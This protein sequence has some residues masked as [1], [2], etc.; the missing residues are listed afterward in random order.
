VVSVTLP[1][2]RGYR[3][4][5]RARQGKARLDARFDAFVGRFRERYGFEPLWL[6]TDDVERPNG[7]GST[8]RLNVVLERSRQYRGFHA[9]EYAYD[10]RKQREV[11]RMFAEE[12]ADGDLRSI[13]GT[14]RRVAGAR[15]T[16]DEIFVCF[17]DFEQ[18]AK[19]EAHGAVTAGELER[20]TS[21]LGLA[22]DVL[23]CVQRFPGTPIVFA[24]TD[25]QA[26]ELRSSA[27]R[28]RWADAYFALVAAHDEF[29]YVGR[30]EIAIHVD[31]KQNFDENYSSNWYYYY[32]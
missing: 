15:L 32:K 19:Y 26:A 13:F 18:V 5:R 6:E 10:P 16:A 17:S 7:T 11:A 12:L 2:D 30:D 8:P 31:S 22:D 3:R 4:A 1:S 29:G 23:W 14:S 21:S 9:A 27:D 28:D 20:F 24:Y 25:E